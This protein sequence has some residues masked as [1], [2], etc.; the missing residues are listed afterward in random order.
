MWIFSSVSV[1]LLVVLVTARTALT[2]RR[3]EICVMRSV[4]FSVRTVS[5]S[6][7][8]QSLVQFLVGCALGLPSGVIL[9]RRVL[10]RISM[11]KRTFPYVS[12]AKEL[13]LSVL[14]L[15]LYLLIGH[16]IAL[17]SIRKWNLAEAVKSS[18]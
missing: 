1:G 18:E 12:G 7:L 3:R 13:L 15:A 5:V 9:S 6:W 17:R 10:E 14:L 11:P 16:V 8:T 4:G 2:E